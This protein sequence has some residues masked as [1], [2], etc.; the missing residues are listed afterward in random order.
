MGNFTHVCKR[1]FSFTTEEAGQILLTSL[2]AAFALSFRNWGTGESVDIVMGFTNLLVYFTAVSVAITLMVVMQKL[3]G[4]K[5]GYEISYE[6][7]K[8]GLLF[9]VLITFLTNGW[10]PV[11]FTGALN[12]NIIQRLRVGIFM[13]RFKH[14]E[15]GIINAAGPLSLLLVLLIIQPLYMATEAT[16]I[17]MLLKAFAL[18]MVF[19]LLPIPLFHGV[20]VEEGGR[21]V[22]DWHGSTFGFNLFMANRFLFVFF[23][24]TMVAYTILALATGIFSFLLSILIAIV[25]TAVFYIKLEAD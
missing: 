16:A 10:V 24:L 20:K 1:Y 2:V 11:F 22:Y 8:M 12:C 4:L 9:S 13:P 23:F 7:W 14:W 15:F 17:Y 21:T 18:T 19:S 6:M 25:L 3:A 5:K